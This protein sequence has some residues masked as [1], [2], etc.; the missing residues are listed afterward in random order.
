MCALHQVSYQRQESETDD[1]IVEVL[2]PGAIE[3][4][5]LCASIYRDFSM[6]FMFCTAVMGLNKLRMLNV[7]G[8][9]LEH[10]FSDD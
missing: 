2:D 9:D 7:G 8:V 10:H 6:I 4:V 5:D 3:E 1:K